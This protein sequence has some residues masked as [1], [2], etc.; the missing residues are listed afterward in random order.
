M[1]AEPNWKIRPALG[2]ESRCLGAGSGPAVVTPMSG[3]WHLPAQPR[4]TPL[5]KGVPKARLGITTLPQPAEAACLGGEGCRQGSP[6]PHSSQT[7]SCQCWAA[8]R[9]KAAESLPALWA[10][11][12]QDLALCGCPSPCQGAA[13]M[14][15]SRVLVLIPQAPQASVFPATTRS[16]FP[17]TSSLTLAALSAALE[18]PPPPPTSLVKYQHLC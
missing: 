7:P 2:W 4:E 11:L 3:Q 16:L 10:P 13:E 5:A 6:C 8:D 18:R 17:I 1:G 14:V 15:F 12:H 9:Q